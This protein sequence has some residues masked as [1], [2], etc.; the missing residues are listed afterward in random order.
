MSITYFISKR[1]LISHHKIGYI[2]FISII[3]IIGLSVGVAALIL[4]ISILNGFEREIETKLIGFDSHIR[5]RL[6]F[7]ETVDSTSHIEER[8]YEY[9]GVRHVVPYIHIQAM[10]RHGKE[11]DGVVVEGISEEDIGK[12]LQLS[13]IVTEGDIE[14]NLKDGSDGIVIGKKLADYLN[15]DLSSNVY[16]FA[17]R[18]LPGA[19]GYSRVGKFKITGIYDSG[20]SDYD[21]IFV[22]T[23]LSAAQDL[24]ELGDRFS[25]FQIMLDDAFQA[26]NIAV[27]IN[28][29]LGYPYHALSWTDLHSTLFEWLNVQRIPILLI[30]GLIAV[31]A[32][33]NIVSTLMMIVIEKTRDIGVL[34]TMG[35]NRAQTVSIF[36]LDGL[37]IGVAG[38]LLG[39]I[40]STALAWIQNRFGL[41]SIPRDVYF[42]NQLPILLQW[43]N[44]LIIGIGAILFSMTATIY[45]ALKAVKLTAAEATRYE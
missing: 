35:V 36:L 37:I 19:T 2:S 20:M 21:D 43:Q 45:P 1:H 14:F 16:L 18:G 33:F 27:N 41:I 9:P 11:A 3:S 6:F 26:D 24:F 25:G 23:S 39:F 22:Y 28:E 31:V 44:Y 34:K 13:N 5:L 7:N 42:M 12:T 40:I 29:D 17:F 10:I 30:F 32:V 15:V 8:L 38:T 4:T